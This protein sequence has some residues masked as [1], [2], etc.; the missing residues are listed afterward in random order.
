MRLS[1]VGVRSSDKIKTEALE[2]VPKKLSDFFDRNLLQHIDLECV[3]IDWTSPSDR[4]ALW[5]LPEEDRPTAAAGAVERADAEAQ[6]RRRQHAS[7]G[8]VSGQ[9]GS[10]AASRT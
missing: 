9:H 3:I 8:R 5:G 4:N 6:A 10:L 7:I 2:H 1:K